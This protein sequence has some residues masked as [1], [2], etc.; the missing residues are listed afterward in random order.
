[1]DQILFYDGLPHNSAISY[2]LNTFAD[3]H[4][5]H[6]T[7]NIFHTWLRMMHNSQK[8]HLLCLLPSHPSL[9]FVECTNSDLLKSPQC[10]FKVCWLRRPAVLGYTA[11]GAGGWGGVAIRGRE[12]TARWLDHN[13]NTLGH[14]WMFKKKKKDQLFPLQLRPT[15]YY[16]H[17]AE[18]TITQRK[19]WCSAAVCFLHLNQKRSETSTLV[20]QTKPRIWVKDETGEKNLWRT[21]GGTCST[22]QTFSQVL[23]GFFPH[24]PH[25]SSLLI[26]S[27][28]PTVSTTV[29]FSWTLLS[30]RSYVRGR[31]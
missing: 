30:C 31:R 21:H 24:H 27:P 29:S 18:R 10:A 23:E 3:P 13:I 28:K 12:S 6:I 26:W 4:I 20:L 17:F 1:M 11:D 5:T 16:F 25:L 22:T 7:L 2:W 15:S 19:T 9:I 8:M 14:S